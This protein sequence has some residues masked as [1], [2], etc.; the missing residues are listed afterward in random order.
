MFH[1]YALYPHMTVYDNMAF[2]LR[3]AK[4]SEAEIKEAV[5]AAA[6]KLHSA[7]FSTGCR[8]RF[9]GGQRQRVPSAGR[10]CA[11]P[12]G[13]REGGGSTLFDET[14]LEP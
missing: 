7:V 6:N 3:I 14:A 8:R 1:T 4:K 5:M 2:S 10:S 13:G 12:N 9:R 11:T